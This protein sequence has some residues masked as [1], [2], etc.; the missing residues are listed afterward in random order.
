MRNVFCFIALVLGLL[1]TSQAV[2]GDWPQFRGPN[3]AGV[4]EAAR[5]PQEWSADQNVQWKVAVPGVAWS[6]PIV[7]GDKVFVTTAVT[8]N[9][10]KP[11]ADFGGRGR[12][13]FEGGG[14]RPGA[15]G[16]ENPT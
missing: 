5:W 4:A 11:R 7:W 2:A 10:R 14:G 3:G 8:D 12:P 16:D 15:R 6:S 13:P 1:L 9:Q